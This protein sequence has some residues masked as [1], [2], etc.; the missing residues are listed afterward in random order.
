MATTRKSQ[1]LHDIPDM[2]RP[3]TPAEIG[4]Q[5]READLR[6]DD[7]IAAEAFTASKWVPRWDTISQTPRRILLACV[8]VGTLGAGAFLGGVGKSWMETSQSNHQ[9]A[10][11]MRTSIPVVP[12]LQVD[13]D[14]GKFDGKLIDVVMSINRGG[15]Y[16]S[17]KGLYLQEFE[18]GMSL[19]VFESAFAGFLAEGEKPDAIVTRYIGKTVRARGTIRSFGQGKDG[20][21][22]M[23]MVV[24]AP[25]L[26]SE[27][28][29]R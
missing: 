5:L 19:V 18:G 26:L 25:G 7:P 24:Y 4:A 10:M 20:G 23:S 1:T 12:A 6:L 22:R 13:V 27:M 29:Q 28:P 8:L 17:G 9:I 11:A 3:L 14:P 2:T 16:K 21:K 15:V